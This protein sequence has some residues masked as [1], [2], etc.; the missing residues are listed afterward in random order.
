[1]TPVS[2]HQSTCSMSSE[3]FPSASV[4]TA[5][6]PVRTV[7]FSTSGVGSFAP[8]SCTLGSSI[9][10][11]SSCSVTYNTSAGGSQTITGAYSGSTDDIP[12]SGTFTLDV[13]GTCS[14]FN[15]IL[16]G[17]SAGSTAWIASNLTGWK[18]LDLIPTRVRF[19][20]GPATSQ[21]FVVTFDHTKTSGQNVFR[22]L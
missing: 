14:N 12:S 17:Q 19:C 7:N 22:G 13:L 8:S 3:P 1:Y 11:S 9:G 21:E 15:G 10:N 20:G 4:E 6:P 5:V 18:E 2:M 16:E